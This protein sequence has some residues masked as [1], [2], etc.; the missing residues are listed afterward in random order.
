MIGLSLRHDL[1]FRHNLSLRHHLSLRHD[2]FL[3][4]DL[5]PRDMLLRAR[6]SATPTRFVTPTRSVHP[7]W[8]ICQS[9]PKVFCEPLINFIILRK[10]LPGSTFV[11]REFHRKWQSQTSFGLLVP[12]IKPR[13]MFFSMREYAP[14]LFDLDLSMHICSFLTLFKI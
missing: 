7:R 9:G 14:L 6:R 11:I 4:D 1:L 8:L 5:S 13:F 10:D 12:P 2:L 3:W